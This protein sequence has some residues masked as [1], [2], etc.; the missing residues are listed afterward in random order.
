[1]ATVGT[2]RGTVTE[3]SPGDG[4]VYKCSWERLTRIMEFDYDG[5]TTGWVVGE[6]LTLT[7][8]T[9]TAELVSITD[10][11]ATGH[12]TIRL[13]TGTV[14]ANNTHIVGAAGV[15]DVNGAVTAVTGATV[16]SAIPAAMAAHVDRSIQILGTFGAAATVVWEGSIDGTTWAT[17]TDPQGNAISKTAAGLEHCVEQ[18]L[19]ARPSLA[20]GG[21]VDTDIDVHAVIRRPTGMRK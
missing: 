12:M 7:S 6:T 20:S 15:A 16:G 10:N 2:V 5:G 19:Y 14:P 11:G 21:D 1:M 9:G 18:V 13:L 17:L 4:S 3:V 8:P